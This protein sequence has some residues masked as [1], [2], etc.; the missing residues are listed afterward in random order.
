MLQDRTASVIL[1]TNLVILMNLAVHLAK[2][3]F[4]VYG[5]IIHI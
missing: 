3:A 4:D 2:A 5:Q 1:V